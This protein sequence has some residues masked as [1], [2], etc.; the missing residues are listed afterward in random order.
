M[1][2]FDRQAVFQRVVHSIETTLLDARIIKRGFAENLARNRAGVN[3]RATQ[4]FTALDK[5]DALAEISSL[6]GSLFAGRTGAD[7]NQ[8][9]RLHSNSPQ[10]RVRKFSYHYLLVDLR[11]S[12]LTC[13]IRLAKR[14]GSYAEGFCSS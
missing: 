2:F 9:I 6:R 11:S 4:D 5:G 8:I 14:A 1:K 12:A 3:A 10:R 13:R 7:Y